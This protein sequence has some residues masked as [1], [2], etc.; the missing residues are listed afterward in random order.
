MAFASQSSSAVIVLPVSF[1]IL[2][3]GVWETP[4]RR[5]GGGR[6]LPPTASPGVPPG[7]HSSAPQFP[8]LK[9]CST[10]KEDA[11]AQLLPTPPPPFF[12]TLPSE[13]PKSFAMA[14][15]S[16]P[17]SAVIVH[18]V[19]FAFLGAEVWEIRG[20]G[21]AWGGFCLS[22]HLPGCRRGHARAPNCFRH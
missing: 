9:T 2:G 15:A 11:G 1:A 22:L 6:S 10:K 4:G 3:M 16:Q 18:P 12:V 8:A 14:F 19:L 21:R 7:P 17:S 13:K 20:T 5:E